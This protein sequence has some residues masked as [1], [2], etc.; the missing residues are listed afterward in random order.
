MRGLAV[1]AIVLCLLTAPSLATI[2]VTLTADQTVLN[3]G[4]STVVRI[5]GQG[6]AAGLY[7]LAGDI[8]ATGDNVLTSTGPFTWSGAFS[9]AFPFSPKTGTAGTDGGWLNFG[10]MQTGWGTPDWTFAKAS[11]VDL[12]DYT[13]T[14]DSVS[15]TVTL[16]LSPKTVSG[17]K[18]LEVDKTSVW[19]Q[20]VPVSISVVPE[21]ATLSLLALGGLALIRRRRSA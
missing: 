9:P 11:L 18:G 20:I 2:M 15:G 21:P 16:T 14:A 5:W 7:S 17:Y 6:D 3:Y 1:I 12:A 8:L 10:S 19:G 4:Q 13:V